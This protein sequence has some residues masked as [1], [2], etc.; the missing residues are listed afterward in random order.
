M[1]DLY[2]V[3]EYNLL[4]SALGNELDVRRDNILLLSSFVFPSIVMLDTR[5]NIDSKVAELRIF[6]LE[7]LDNL[8]TGEI[9]QIVLPLLDDLTV[10]ERLAHLSSKFPQDQLEPGD[11]FN[12]IVNQH[13]DE[14]FFWTRSCLLYLI[15]QLK[16]EEHAFRVLNSMND[17]EPI[18]RETCAWSIAQLD[19]PDI[20]RT[21]VAHSGDAHHS[22]KETV[23][24]LLSRLPPAEPEPA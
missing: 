16:V 22:V 21:L 10:S 2:D 4:H 19:P 9:K 12:E 1:E 14:A 3:D 24:A 17:K 15:G 13:F 8:L 20:R 6:A 7:V 18:I 5:A 23:Q 11:R